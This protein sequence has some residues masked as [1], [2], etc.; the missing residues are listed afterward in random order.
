VPSA[1]LDAP[2]VVPAVPSAAAAVDPAPVRSAAPTVPTDGRRPPLPVPVVAAAALAVLESLGL[3]AL[4]LT[5][6][7][8]VF[9]PGAG[10]DGMLVAVTLLLLAGWIVVCAGGGASLIDGAGR[11]LLVA[12]ASGEIVLLLVLALAGVL[13]ADGV[14]LVVLGPLGGLPVPALAL[15]GL[16]VPTAKLLLATAPSAVAWVEAGGRP[17][18]RR[19]APVVE[20]RALRGITVACIGLALTGV[21][22]F[23][24]PADTA[25]TPSTAAVDAP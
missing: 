20:H 24:G 13:G 8:G 17:R 2:R 15:L 1:L 21:A 9:G 19:A 6:L 7:D 5:S 10:S 14:W 3:L 25:T 22:L 18:A 16:G 12:V 23:G 4:G 11:Q